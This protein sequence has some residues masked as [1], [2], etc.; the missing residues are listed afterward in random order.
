M[1]CRQESGQTMVLRMD[2]ARFMLYNNRGTGRSSIMTGLS[3]HNQRIEHLW[4]RL[5][6]GGYNIQKYNILLIT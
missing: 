3:V 2:V 1:D 5:E 6:G 4:R